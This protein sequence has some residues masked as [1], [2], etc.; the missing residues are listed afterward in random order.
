[1]ILKNILIHIPMAVEPIPPIFKAISQEKYFTVAS[2]I[3][4]IEEYQG[5]M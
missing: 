5:G 2:R 1:M 3:I 4:G